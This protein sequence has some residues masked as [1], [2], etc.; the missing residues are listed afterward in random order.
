MLE[1]GGRGGAAPAQQRANP[2][3]EL[4]QIERLGQVIVRPQV[5]A[6]HPVGQ[7]IER[8][9]H[10]HRHTGPAG[11]QAAQHIQ[12]AEAGQ[13]DVEDRQVVALDRQCVVRLL[14][15][16]DHVDRIGALDQGPA[17]RIREDRVVLDEEYSHGAQS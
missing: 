12:A 13:A 6:A 16:S 9:E 7:R 14:A 17:E 10:Q 1:K 5:E 4:R 3:L 8:S 11:P 2:C 15:V